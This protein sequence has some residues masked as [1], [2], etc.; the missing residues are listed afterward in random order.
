MIQNILSLIFSKESNKVPN[1]V[2]Y[3]YVTQVIYKK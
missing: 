3:I 2:P 1:G